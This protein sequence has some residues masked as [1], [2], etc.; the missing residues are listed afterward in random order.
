MKLHKENIWLLL[1]LIFMIGAILLMTSCN[2]TK[3]V[4]KSPTATEKVAMEYIKRYPPR[5]DT[6]Y[7]PGKI[8]TKD[9]T[10]Y[11]TVPL[12][13]PVKERY[14]EQHFKEIL[15]HDTLKITDRSFAEGLAKRVD[16]LE[17]NE[18][19]L[20]AELKEWK[21]EAY[22]HRGIWIGIIVF[23]AVRLFYK[24]LRPLLKVYFKI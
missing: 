7:I 19:A 2:A 6:Q 11:D 23:F 22:V 3:Q 4:L 17:L 12:P 14:T 16:A 15:V 8:I 1:A 13:Y 18:K 10:I 20:K 5:N 24:V 21:T 9:T